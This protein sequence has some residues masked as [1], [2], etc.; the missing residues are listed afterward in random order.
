MYSENFDLN[1]Q[2]RVSVLM[3]DDQ[4]I[5][6][7]VI[8]KIL[9]AD[10]NAK[11]H[12]CQ[13][14]LEAI[15][16]AEEIKPTVILQDLIM[17]E[18][19]GL[20]LVKQFRANPL[21]K[22]I[23]MIVLSSTED[24]ST[25]YQAFLSGANDYMVK[26]PD[27]LEILARIKYHSQA[28]TNYCQK[29]RALELLKKSQ[30][31]L[32][33][34]LLQAESY[35]ESLLPEKIDNEYVSCD[36]VYQ[37]S[38]MLG[39]DCFG[40]HFLDEDNFAMY[41]V[42][43]CGHGVGAALLSVSTMNVLRSQSLSNVDFREP[44]QVLKAMSLAFDM[45][46]QNGM[47]F[48]A[49]YGVFNTKTRTLKYS[50]G[51][52]P[53]AI[54]KSTKGL[55]FLSTNGLVVGGDVDFEYKQEEVEVAESSSLYIFSDGVYEVE[56]ANSKEMMT[57]QDFAEILKDEDSCL[58]TKEKVQTIQGKEIFEDDFSLCRIFIK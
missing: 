30:E 20:E 27:K 44:N 56:K 10:S 52:H 43:V 33:A 36:W 42:D 40:Y 1:T 8:K 26:L 5:F 49:W 58:S 25:K 55:E 37:S 6:G 14:P 17:P 7:E 18:I 15:K 19:D 51:G 53:P 28:Y 50:S 22:N 13:N 2:N 3:I 23:P 48:T 11:F 41:L 12:F 16:I 31:A 32:K 4:A 34:E 39:G 29:N 21:T 57:L 24:A 9:S 54:L 35:V 45:D 47:F 38:T 46:R